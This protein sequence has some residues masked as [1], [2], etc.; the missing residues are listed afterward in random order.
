MPRNGGEKDALAKRL[1]EENVKMGTNPVLIL[2]EAHDL[3]EE[4][5]IALKRLWDSG[6][7]FKLLSIIL[8]GQGGVNRYSAN[9]GLKRNLEENMWVREFSERCYVVDLGS[10]NGSMAQY[11]DYRFKKIGGN[12][13]KS[14][15]DKALHLLAKR[16]DVPQLANNIAIRAMQNAYRD[17]KTQVLP[18]HVAEA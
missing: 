11:L 4:A 15:S 17:G 7:I 8:V 10:L 9:Y 3:Q 18:E 2:D 14:F 5:F 13:N 6:M 1:L 12:I 16:A